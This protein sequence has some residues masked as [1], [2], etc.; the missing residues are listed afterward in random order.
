MKVSIYKGPEG[1]LSVL[2]QASP[3]AGLV[4]VVIP[5]VTIED[6]QEK[7]RPVVDAMRPPKRLRPAPLQLE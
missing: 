2:A 7:V 3:G 4:P 5:L 1:T 6:I